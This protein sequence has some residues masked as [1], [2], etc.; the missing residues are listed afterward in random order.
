[1][2]GATG[3]EP[4]TSSVT[5]QRFSRENKGRFNLRLGNSVHKTLRFDSATGKVETRFQSRARAS[6]RPQ[7][8]NPGAGRTG[9][10]QIITTDLIDND[11]KTVSLAPAVVNAHARRPRRSTLRAGRRP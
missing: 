2:A 5:G 7:K 4:A 11:G 6:P 1:M 9:I 10:P 8:R 3:L